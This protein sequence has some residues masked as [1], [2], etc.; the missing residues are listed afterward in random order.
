MAPQLAPAALAPGLAGLLL[1]DFVTAC[2]T[3]GFETAAA[4]LVGLSAEDVQALKS[5][6]E[7]LLQTEAEGLAR[8]CD[9]RQWAE[10]SDDKAFPVADEEATR[11]QEALVEAHFV[12][13]ITQEVIA[14][15]V[16]CSDGQT[17][18]RAAIQQWFAQGRNTSP[19]TNLRLDSTISFPCIILRNVIH[20]AVPEALARFQ[21]LKESTHLVRL[22]Q[23]QYRGTN[24]IWPHP[25][26]GVL[27]LFPLV[28]M[29]STDPWM[30]LDA[31]S[32]MWLLWLATHQRYFN[33]SRVGRM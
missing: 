12:C 11:T 14:D 13:P 27:L 32:F 5:T 24:S 23:F 8:L 31:P 17:Y 2:T 21:G 15:P 4:D 33:S 20:A 25:F 29:S 19:A 10:S 6:T 9:W 22:C 1:S 18:E 7:I 16:V 26:R 28:R 30:K 3:E